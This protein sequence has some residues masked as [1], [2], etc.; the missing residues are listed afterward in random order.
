MITSQFPP[1]E[2]E[3]L[4]SWLVRLY[5]LSGFPNI[6][7]FLDSLGIKNRFLK[8]HELFGETIHDCAHFFSDNK[9]DK[10]LAHS[11]LALWQLSLTDLASK[12][13]NKIQRP[14][15]QQSHMNE[16]LIFN[17]DTS[18]HSC[19]VCRL[20]D[21]KAFGTTYWHAQHQLPS[22]Y[23][24][25]KH[26]VVLDSGLM[27]IKN[28]FTAVLPHDV[29]NWCPSVQS[30]SAALDN[31]QAFYESLFFACTLSP[32]YSV[33]LRAQIDK[34]LDLCSRN[35]VARKR[36]CD[37]FNPHFE[38]ALGPDILNYLFRDY[39][40]PNNRS[41]TNIL[42]NFLANIYQS[43]GVRNPIYWIAVA[44]WLKDDTNLMLG[45]C[46]EFTGATI[47]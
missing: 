36:I 13:F 5:K 42:R 14:L 46:H 19:A 12:N 4:Y 2:G 39:A 40:K 47:L 41:K 11:S 43:I 23:K 29:K 44:Y 3:H 16:Q 15:K 28:L 22:I 1:F 25:I 37:E 6:T 33:Q 10:L 9:V 30:I 20:E 34:K 8:S 18:W 35:L 32:H 17:F 7:S 38:K 27:P 45:E 26:S 21:L 31:W 24:C